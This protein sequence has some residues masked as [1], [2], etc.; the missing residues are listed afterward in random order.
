MFYFFFNGFSTP[1]MKEMVWNLQ[2]FETY[3]FSN[4]SREMS[5]SASWYLL[6]LRIN[7][8]HA[9]SSICPENQSWEVEHTHY[10]LTYRE[11]SKSS[12]KAQIETERV[13]IWPKLFTG[14]LMFWF[15]QS[16][17]SNDPELCG[18]NKKHANDIF[19]MLLLT[20]LSMCTNK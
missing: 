2:N 17:Q 10:E 5:A 7:S 4:L 8:G 14:L 20:S 6:R 3:V 11:R 19:L 13:E 16:S 15:W 12:L 1:E 9:Q 18:K